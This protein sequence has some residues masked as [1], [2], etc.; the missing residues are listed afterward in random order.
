MIET[1]PILCLPTLDFH[2]VRTNRLPATN[3]AGSKVSRATPK[4]GSQ[5]TTAVE[6]EGRNQVE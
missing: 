4:Q 6:W 5:N 3:A 1:P 2:F